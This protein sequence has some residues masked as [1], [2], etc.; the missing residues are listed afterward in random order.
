M[1]VYTFRETRANATD[2]FYPAIITFNKTAS[3]KSV[4]LIGIVMHIN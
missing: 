1:I 3:P 4:L 2:C